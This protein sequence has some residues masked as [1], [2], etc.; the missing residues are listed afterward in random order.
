MKT[1]SP[2]DILLHLKCPNI[3][4]LQGDILEYN[5]DFENTS[6]IFMNCKTFSKDLMKMIANKLKLMP[7]GVVC[8]TSHQ[9]MT[10]FDPSWKCLAKL[11]RLMSW[12][13]A[14]LF[15]HMKSD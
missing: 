15:I 3:R 12:G 6:L 13:C 10:D 9:L 14:N 5:L 11:R 1:N 2:S 7:I 4:L 8:I